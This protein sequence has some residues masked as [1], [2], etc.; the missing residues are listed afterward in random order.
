MQGA[1]NALHPQP[2]NGQELMETGMGERMQEDL[3]SF[4]GHEVTV[5]SDLPEVAE[6]LK[7]VYAQFHLGPGGARAAR[8]ER[9]EGP[10]GLQ[11][12]VKDCLD[13]SS[14]IL[15]DAGGTIYHLKCKDPYTFDFDT[16]GISDPLTFI[17]F[18]ILMELSRRLRDRHLIH[19][20]AVSWQGQGLVLPGP[21]GT[22]KT[23]LTLTLVKRGLK[24]LSD[25]VACF[26]LKPGVLEP[27]PR[28]VN[29]RE[30]SLGMI[31]LSVKTGAP[32]RM[33]SPHEKVWT[34]GIEDIFPGSLSAPCVPRFLLFLRGFGE[35]TR[36]E[37]VSASNAVFA[38]LRFSFCRLN[39][40]TSL[41]MDFAPIIDRMECF[42]LVMGELDEA[43][44]C[45]LRLLN[46]TANGSIRCMP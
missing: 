27:F 34:V 32:P 39:D 15:F 24:F 22:G 6:H 35:K 16:A 3:Y 36:L 17:Q 2:P 40:P 4:L 8:Q 38:L 18:V 23:T 41:L 9:S 37:P 30:D 14:E 10:A 43:V 12:E 45:V 29:L 26:H 20:G 31:G 13:E 42:N 33:T 19:A 25:E 44:D 5:R 28:T 11:V 46:G 1:R 7:S 21:A